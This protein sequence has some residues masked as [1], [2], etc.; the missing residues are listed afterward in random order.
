MS[1]GSDDDELVRQQRMYIDRVDQTIVALLR[2]RIRLGLAVG[3]WKRTHA[4]PLRVEARERDVLARVRQAAGG[5]LTPESVARIF[6]V[7]I[8]ET[9]AAQARAE[10][11]HGC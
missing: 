3:E 7:V 4:V 10:S 11:D 6:A 8:E 9:A 1:T 2:E 5:P